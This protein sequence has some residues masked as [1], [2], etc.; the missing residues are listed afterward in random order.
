MELFYTDMNIETEIAAVITLL[1]LLGGIIGLFVLALA[2]I[3]DFF[4]DYKHQKEEK[5]KAKAI[6]EAIDREIITQSKT[7]K[8]NYPMDF[9]QNLKKEQEKKHTIITEVVYVE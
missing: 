8:I 2:R 4:N 3:G 5:I 7:H 9:V 6:A 1:F